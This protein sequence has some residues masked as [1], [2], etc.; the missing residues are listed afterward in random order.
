[1]DEQ[2]KGK[3]SDHGVLIW[4]PKASTRFKIKREK[5]KIKTRPLPQ[6]KV[7][8]FCFEFTRHKWEEVLATED[9]NEKVDN[10]H[11]YIRG[12]V[13]KHFPEK[14]VVISNLD[15]EWM[16]PSLKVLLRRV[17]KELYRNG[18]TAKFKSLKRS[19]RKKT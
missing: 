7:N 13:D 10:F 18:K 4:A 19:F 17:Q 11:T 1:M 15:K 14:E 2:K 6:S 5:T 3:D 12:M 16:T 9:T 8:E